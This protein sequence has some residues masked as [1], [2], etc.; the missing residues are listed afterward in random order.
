MTYPAHVILRYQLE[1]AMIEGDLALGDLPGA[2]NDGMRRLLGIVPPDDRRGCLQDI[3]WPG[4]AWGYF[5][6][7]TLGA[8]IAAQLFDTAR[9]DQ[10][11]LPEA[12]AEGNFAPLVGWLR[13]TIH[14]RASLLPMD[15]LLVQ[16]T[17]QPLDVATYRRH[18]ERRY[19]DGE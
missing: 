13:Q 3:H 19:L 14:R 12:L 6:T 1:K 10:P 11:T 16:A 4:G 2:W 17:G 5:P 8:M 15:D 9:H 18:L 7:Y